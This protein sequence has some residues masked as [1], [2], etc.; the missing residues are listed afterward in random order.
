MPSGRR[1]T[2]SW[3]A[4]FRREQNICLL[5]MI[6]SMILCLSE[7]KITRFRGSCGRRPTTFKPGCWIG[8]NPNFCH[9]HDELSWSPQVQ[10]STG[11]RLAGE[12]ARP[13]HTE[14]PRNCRRWESL[15]LQSM[16]H[17]Q[18]IEL[19]CADLVV[20]AAFLTFLRLHADAMQIVLF[21]FSDE[22]CIISYDEDENHEQAPG[23]R[24]NGQE[25]R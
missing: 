16:D 9:V 7:I 8:W 17:D 23:M 14:A 18:W 21:C 20:R 12:T 13:P 19:N 5:D 24:M 25:M 11:L 1:Y 6:L 3:G 2:H 4:N 22:G 10:V 15:C